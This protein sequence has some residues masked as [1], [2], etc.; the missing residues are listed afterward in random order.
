MGIAPSSVLMVRDPPPS[1]EPATQGWH[2]HPWKLA[3]DMAIRNASKLSQRLTRHPP[4]LRI[5]LLRASTQVS[6]CAPHKM[7][8]LTSG[9]D[10]WVI[11]GCANTRSFISGGAM[12]KRL[13]RCCTGLRSYEGTVNGRAVRLGA[14]F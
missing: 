13:A 8:E 2:G 12:K 4:H 6:A 3:S 11:S 10:G 14:P 9:L 5:K 1:H 7:L